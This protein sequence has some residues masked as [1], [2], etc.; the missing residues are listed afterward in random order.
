M[1][2]EF[3]LFFGKRKVVLRGTVLSFYSVF[4]AQLEDKGSHE[5]KHAGCKHEK[6]EAD[7]HR[8]AFCEC[9]SSDRGAAVDPPRPWDNAGGA[10]GKHTKTGRERPAQKKGERGNH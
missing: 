7:A 8:E 3:R 4:E 1:N 9:G 2:R 10:L 5:V 6:A